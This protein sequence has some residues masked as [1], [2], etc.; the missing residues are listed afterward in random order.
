[1]GDAIESIHADLAP[2]RRMMRQSEW[3]QLT[4]FPFEV[5][6]TDCCAE[7]EFCSVLTPVYFYPLVFPVLAAGHIPCGWSGDPIPRDWRPNGPGDVPRGKLSVYVV[8][9]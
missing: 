2:A 7:L 4:R 3:L 9:S 8:E 1:M 5:L 6:L